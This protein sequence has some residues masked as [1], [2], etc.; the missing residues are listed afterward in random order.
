M[1]AHASKTAPRIRWFALLAFVIVFL[2]VVAL[3]GCS[4]ETNPILQSLKAGK[5]ESQ[6]ANND[7]DGG[8]SVA[9]DYTAPQPQG[10]G[11]GSAG[12][13]NDYSE[14]FGSTPSTFGS[15]TNSQTFAPPNP[16]GRGSQ[17]Y[18]GNSGD[19]SN[20]RPPDSYTPNSQ[21][22]TSNSSGDQNLSDSDS[23]YAEVR[24]F[25]PVS[26]PQ[27]GPNGTLM[28]FNIRYEF[29][30]GRPQQ[31]RHYYLVIF[32][33]Q[34]LE[35]S[36]RV[37]HPEKVGSL[38]AFVDGWKPEYGPYR[39]AFFEVYANGIKTEIARQVAFPR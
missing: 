15:S 21:S 13:S 8:A 3:S 5:P 10:V 28:S 29:T 18:G 20:S 16:N 31:G 39:A 2:I 26:L 35:A 37:D 7:S 23:R 14:S 24:L 4:E 32:G 6:Q 19:Q 38:V 30:K 12:G 22:Q 36:W 11:G 27:T 34:G 1:N 33:S 9:P 25:Q 17:S